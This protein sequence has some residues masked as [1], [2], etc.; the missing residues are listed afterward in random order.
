MRI[1][2][3]L[4]LPAVTLGST[5]TST[6]TSTS[7]TL[8]DIVN[9]LSELASELG[10]L[11]SSTSS[12][13]CS[14]R[15]F[16]SYLEQYK[17]TFSNDD[18]REEA[19]TNWKEVDKFI[20]E[21]NSDES[22]TYTVSHNRFSI[23]SHDDYLRRFSLGKY[24]TYAPPSPTSTDNFVD[25]AP[26]SVDRKPPKSVDWTSKGKITSVKDQGSCG[27]CWAFSATGAIES[28]YAISNDVT[29]IDFSEQQLVDCDDNDFGCSGGLM[30][31]AFEW[32]EKEGGLCKASDYPYQAAKGQCKE[33]DCTNV[34]GSGLFSFE[35]VPPSDP[36]AMMAALVKQPVSIAIQANQPGFRFYSGGVFNGP[37]GTN[38]DHGVLAVGYGSESDADHESFLRPHPFRPT[39][40]GDFWLVKNSWGPDWG[41]GGY[42]KLGR[43]NKRSPGTC[44]ILLQASY[45]DI[46]PDDVASIDVQTI[47]SMGMGKE[48]V[49]QAEV[50][51]A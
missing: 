38:L 32:E 36:D 37:C 1:S 45:P 47:D 18:E 4:L 50:S 43:S 29:P 3:L 10:A 31:Y 19:F 22:W 6:S 20:S 24:S 40:T 9:S 23:L 39:K 51:I 41:D 35:D 48:K 14:T 11:F 34:E 25:G 27:S 15:R 49:L 30:D 7:T 33:D 26:S 2:Y 44:G 46:A 17:I 28:A 21:H 12:S 8:T 5:T 16:A 42:I 13:S